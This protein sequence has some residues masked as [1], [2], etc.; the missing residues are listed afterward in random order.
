M[1]HTQLLR[2]Y[3]LYARHLIQELHEQPVQRSF[4]IVS[5]LRDEVDKSWE[6]TLTVQELVRLLVCASIVEKEGSGYV[7]RV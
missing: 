5:R 1:W 6:G 7:E 2:L 3:P 4:L